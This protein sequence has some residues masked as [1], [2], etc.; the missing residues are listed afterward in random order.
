MPL[1]EVSP[2]PWTG[3][4]AVRLAVAELPGAQRDAV[5][6][7]ELVGMGIVEAANILGWGESRM[8]V[9]LFRARRR[10]RE[11]LKSHVCEEPEDAPAREK[12]G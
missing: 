9:T 11:L 12:E 6:L 10:L 3:D 2:A 1:V 5:V 4:D 8:K 7:C